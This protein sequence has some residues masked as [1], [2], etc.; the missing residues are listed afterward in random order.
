MITKILSNVS[1]GF[2]TDEGQQALNK[3]NELQKYDGWKIH[4]GLLVQIAN[5]LV[6]TLLTKGF[7]EL[8]KEDKD[9]QQRAIFISKEIIDFLLNPE[10]ALNKLNAI[11]LH[12]Q[13]LEANLTKGRPSGSNPKG[14]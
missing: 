7:T 4:Q 9:V 13:K 1:R 5:E 6:L 2:G 10:T 14:K 3:Y 8:S 12:N 11:K